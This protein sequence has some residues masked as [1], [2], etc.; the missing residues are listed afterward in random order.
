MTFLISGPLL[1]PNRGH[2]PGAPNYDLEGSMKGLAPPSQGTSKCQPKL[3]SIQT[4]DSI[5]RSSFVSLS[6]AGWAGR[7]LGHCFLKPFFCVQEMMGSLQ[8]SVC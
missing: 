5:Y 3:T 1:G 8:L 6:A 7:G 4:K 2:S